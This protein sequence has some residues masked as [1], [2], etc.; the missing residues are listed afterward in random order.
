MAGEWSPFQGP[1]GGRSRVPR[2]WKGEGP[3]TP[4]VA[5]PRWSSPPVVS[6]RDCEEATPKALWVSTGR[7]LPDRHPPSEARWVR[8]QGSCP[9]FEPPRHESRISIRYY[10]YHFLY[11][12]YTLLILEIDMFIINNSRFYY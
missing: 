2:S 7:R 6:P 12:A 4:T 9:E 10:P 3:G 1:V 11:T 5:P 8:R